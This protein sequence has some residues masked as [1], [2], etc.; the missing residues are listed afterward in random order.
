[1]GTFCVLSNGKGVI[2]WF[3]KKV[4]ISACLKEDLSYQGR[5]GVVGAESMQGELKCFCV[6][7][8]TRRMRLLGGGRVI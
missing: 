1:M 6:K 7:D 3:P 4:S 5:L 8:G 2:N